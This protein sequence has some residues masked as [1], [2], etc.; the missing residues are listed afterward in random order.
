MT[1][2]TD[3]LAG[4]RAAFDARASDRTADLTWL[5]RVR[6]VAWR[7]F[8]EMGFPTSDLEEWRFTP[9]HAIASRAFAPPRTDP[10]AVAPRLV[11]SAAFGLGGARLVLVDGRYSPR[12]SRLE[13]LPVGARAGSLRSLVDEDP[14]VAALWVAQIVRHENHPFAALNAALWEDGACVVLPRG[15]LAERPI[16]IVHVAS[17]EGTVAMHPRTLVVAGEAAQARVVEG[18]TGPEGA[19][20]LTNAVTEIALGASAVV[21][22]VRAQNESA[23]AYHMASLGA[24]LERGATFSSHSVTFGGAITRNDVGVVLDG[25]GAECTL[26]GAYLADGDRLVDN[27]TAID[28]ARAHCSSHE[29]YKGILSGRGRGVFNGKVYV[30][31]DAQKTDAKQTNQ[32]LLLSDEAQIQTKPQLE[33]FADDVKCT[34]GATVGQLD[35]DAMFYLRSRGIPAEEAR[36]LLIHSFAADVLDRIPIEAVRERLDEMLVERLPR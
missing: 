29:L 25:E 33:I 4:W 11:D 35:R 2:T 16:E 9:V 17:G 15:A 27:H 26:N 20:Y 34:H 22:H 5:D 28:H 1:T 3:A 10:D 30:R 21:D 12:H 6:D 8:V 36:A 31:P 24:R 18:Y 13:G 23:A 14:E 19:V 32:S 7:R